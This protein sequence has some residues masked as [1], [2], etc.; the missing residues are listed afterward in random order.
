M[1]RIAVSLPGL[2]LALCALA[3]APA[4]PASATD[5]PQPRRL[6]DL[7]GPVSFPGSSAH[8]PVGAGTDPAAAIAHA[9][10][11]PDVL[12][13]LERCAA[14]GY[15]R[16]PERDTALVRS[17]PP[18]T[19]VVLALE[20]PGLVP[21]EGMV[22]A[23]IVQVGTALDYAGNPSTQVSGGLVFFVTATGE[24]RAAEDVPGFAD[25]ATFD[26]HPTGARGEP[27][28]YTE[29]V[30]QCLRDYTFC[31]GVGNLTCVASALLP[32]NGWWSVARASLCVA[33]NTIRCIYGF[34]KCWRDE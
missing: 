1:K 24:M 14:R 28:F 10:T 5:L 15:L 11:M 12:W 19:V 8:L 9:R 27:V 7:D 34:A 13:A 4:P 26:A 23:P 3:T 25:D 33:S 31:A 22:G 2:C 20:R 30:V 18:A 6:P 16:H 21:P 17:D 29:G 32:P